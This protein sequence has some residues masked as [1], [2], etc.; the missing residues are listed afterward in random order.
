MVSQILVLC[1]SC[2]CD[3]ALRAALRAPLKIQR[4]LRK[5]P[6]RSPE[7][8]S[9][10][11]RRGPST[12]RLCCCAGAVRFC[13]SSPRAHGQCRALG[14]LV[15]AHCV[16]AGVHRGSCVRVHCT[17]G[18]VRCVALPP[19]LPSPPLPAAH[20]RPYAVV[21]AAALRREHPRARRR[22]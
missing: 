14:Q 4:P 11:A 9:G 18:E 7:A 1:P 13:T 5:R 17:T 2:D 19:P 12:S 22:S 3:G 8:R 21:R 15:R 10:H 6:A 20:T 16:T